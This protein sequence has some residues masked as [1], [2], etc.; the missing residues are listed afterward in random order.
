MTYA[1]KSFSFNWSAVPTATFYRVGSSPVPDSGASGGVRV[2]ADKISALT[3]QMN[4]IELTSKVGGLFMQN[5]F[6]Q[7]C[8]DVGCGPWSA[9][10]K[11]DP[12]S[13]VGYFKSV[14]AIHTEQLGKAVAISGDGK[15]IALGAPEY[16]NAAGRVVVYTNRDGKGW[17]SST[18]LA[19]ALPNA[20]DRFGQAVALSDDGDTLA[21]GVPG[22][23]G[24][25]VVMVFRRMEADGRSYWAQYKSLPSNTAQGNETGASV[26]ISGDGRT[27][28]FGAPGQNYGAGAVYVADL[29]LTALPI[30][31]FPPVQTVGARFG[32]RLALSA[33]S[34][35]LI[36]GMARTGSSASRALIFRGSSL[37]W[38]A[39]NSLQ[40]PNNWMP[41]GFVPNVALS[42]DGT[43]AALGDLQSWG[44]YFRMDAGN[45]I[46]TG[47][48]FD[49]DYS[50]G[51]LA[52]SFDG[53]RLL[54]SLESSRA[55]G[56]GVWAVPESD[57]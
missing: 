51:P 18:P 26:A 15:T 22:I 25:G 24:Q 38:Q 5:Y 52:F 2:E 3:L 10:A 47:G 35:S 41:L 53:K 32:E 45:Y 28:A 1:V 48:R 23:F 4:G 12:N 14:D 20:G 55:R 34:K 29:S 43:R 56:E 9:S 49:Q 17:V 54:V 40:D 27:V 31:L 30:A 21:V 16:S 36:A 7:A 13:A 44:I 42:G 46:Y 33:D 37:Q 8:N 57:P 19:I 11:A 50:G 6:V 39:T